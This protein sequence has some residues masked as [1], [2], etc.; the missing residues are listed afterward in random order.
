M[1]L[2]TLRSE[3][4]IGALTD[5]LYPNLTPQSRSTVEAALLKANP[6]LARAEAF[7][8]GAVV[9]LPP[10]AGLEPRPA[11][12]GKDPAADLRAILK[13]A[14]ADYREQITIGLK[15]AMGE[16]S[17]QQGLLASETIAPAI[18]GDPGAQ[19]IAKGL[20]EWL[21]QRMDTLENN[22]Q[23]L[24]T[25]FEAIAKDLDTMA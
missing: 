17:N 1:Q 7:R 22:R 19:E 15:T 9:I 6:Q 13:A 23:Q 25:A 5:R 3:T 21:R 11:E 8:P 20:S 14:V 18:G 24:D 2:T 10:V 16:I 12:V 4:D